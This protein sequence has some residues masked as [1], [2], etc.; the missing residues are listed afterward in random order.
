EILT[1]LHLN[2]QS[3]LILLYD[4]LDTLKEASLCGLGGLTHL[5]VL[6][7]LKYFGNDFGIGDIQ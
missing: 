3:N 6:S 7:S 5:S 2:T 4:L 1:D